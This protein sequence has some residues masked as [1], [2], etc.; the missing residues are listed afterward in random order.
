MENA[1]RQ[2]LWGSALFGLCFGCGAE[3]TTAG[4]ASEDGVSANGAALTYHADVRALIEQKCVGCHQEGNI[5]PLP[6]TSYAEVYAVRAAV[7]AS[8]QSGSMPPWKA[9][10]ECNDYLND[11]SLSMEEREKLLGWIEQGAEEGAE[12]AYVPAA[13]APE[14]F[15]ESLELALPE[16]YTP[17]GAP[18]D[19]RCL[20]VEWPEATTQFV[21]GLRMVPDRLDLLHHVIA[22]VAAPE[23]AEDYRAMDAAEPGPGYT[24]FGG[25][26]AVGAQASGRPFQIGGWV[27]GSPG[28]PFPEGTGIEIAPG[29]LLIL[30][31]HY[32]SLSAHPGPDQSR[33]QL[34]LAD[35]VDKPAMTFLALDPR[36]L[37]PGGMPIAAGEPSTVHESIIDVTRLFGPLGGARIGLGQGDPFVVYQAGMHM[38]ELGH[39]GGASIVRSDGSET[40]LIQ[41]DDWDFNW[42]TAY[43]LREPV[44][45]ESGDLLRI[46]CEW[47][48]SQANQSFVGSEQ[49][50]SRDVE[51]GEGTGD[52]MCLAPLFVTAR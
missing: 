20:L 49:R 32:N 11:F 40:C 5:G 14:P 44:E 16:P 24:C 50:K 42:Q 26:N 38:H 2:V 41:I 3:E 8:V 48:N 31:M 33:I 13:S 22:Y 27:P 34:R 51:W 21:T 47:D 18:D 4:P 30:Q 46:H 37:A 35:R 12:E 36:W 43:R 15:V 39:K 7:A 9:S 29:S 23:Q 10:S 6:L 19:Y 28:G 25:P 52:E 45:V 1:H 17:Q